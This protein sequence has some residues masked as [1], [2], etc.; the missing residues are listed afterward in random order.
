MGSYK[1][2]QTV[3]KEVE[4][5]PCPCCGHEQLSVF[6]CDRD[7][8]MSCAAATVHCENC[9]HEVRVDGRSI[10]CDSGRKCQFVAIGRWNAQY[11]QYGKP[12]PTIP[13][14]IEALQKELETVK[15]ENITLKTVIMLE[16][17]KV[18]FPGPFSDQQEMYIRFQKIMNEFE[19]RGRRNKNV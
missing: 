1:Y 13:P 17:M 8:S 19:H 6:N 16:D 10:E 3:E 14:D 11:K 2:L 7:D 5:S 9:G 12:K 4:V 18:A 15:E